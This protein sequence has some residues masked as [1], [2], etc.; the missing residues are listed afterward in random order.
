[1]TFKRI[2]FPQFSNR[3]KILELSSGCIQ[4]DAYDEYPLFGLPPTTIVI[5]PEVIAP[6]LDRDWVKSPTFFQ[7]PSLYSAIVDVYLGEPFV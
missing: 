7:P 4:K 1:M 6:W 5:D 3:A 2:E